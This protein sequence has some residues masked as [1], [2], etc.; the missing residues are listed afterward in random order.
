M[1][2]FTSQ[3]IRK[4]IE[5]RRYPES[6]QARIDAGI[7]DMSPEAIAARRA[8]L[9]YEP[10]FHG[11]APLETIIRNRGR[12]RLPFYAGQDPMLAASYADPFRNGIVSP[13][14]INTKGYDIVD[15]NGNFWSDLGP[16][17]TDNIGVR[18]KTL[19]RQVEAD[20]RAFENDMTVDGVEL[21]STDDYAMTA[22]RGGS[23]G[24]LFYNVKDPGPTD[25]TYLHDEGMLRQ[26]FDPSVDIDTSDFDNLVESFVD[27]YDYMGGTEAIVLDP[28]TV[29][30]TNLAAFDP[31]YKGEHILGGLGAGAVGLLSLMG[32]DD[33]EA[34][35]ITKGGKQIIEAY[36]GS[37]HKFD[38]FSM[39]AIGSGAGAQAYGHGLYFTDDMGI[40]KEYRPM[41]VRAGAMHKRYI[42]AL[43]AG[44]E[45]AAAIWERA[46]LTDNA[47]DIR[48]RYSTGDWDD[49]TVEIAMSIADE[50]EMM[51]EFGSLSR[52]HINVDPETLLDW[53][54]PLSEQ[55][56]VLDAMKRYVAENP[57]HGNQL[58]NRTI[59]EVLDDPS[60]RGFDI[61]NHLSDYRTPDDYG[62]NQEISSRVAKEMGIPGTRYPN[63]SGSYNY[64]MFDDEPIE[65]VDN[66]SVIMGLTPP[67]PGDAV[68]SDSVRMGQPGVQDH[69]NLV[70]QRMQQLGIADDPLYDRGMIL[71]FKENIVTGD[72]QLAFPTIATEIIRGII[73]IA[74]QRETG[75]YNPISIM[76]VML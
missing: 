6:V 37:P 72:K 33:A 59:A 68:P 8:D 21:L 49:E 74:T 9:G 10:F 16:E 14:S 61:Y 73:D 7:L 46:R 48:A 2:S 66:L 26:L 56:K 75:V 60:A 65:I 58:S 20:K 35:I 13:V 40:A 3:L 23:P 54:K 22:K 39:D 28:S 30:A 47:D 63:S 53:D 19:R 38:K 64:V 18:N 29:R 5:A 57:P 34:G 17:M 51:P 42:E 31:E 62:I 55:T 76:D 44:D 43:S 1:S 32:S 36:H 24:L 50:M 71:P 45:K 4:L 27:S 12:V 15:A 11:G 69:F 25:L 41:T 70:N 52:V 67:S